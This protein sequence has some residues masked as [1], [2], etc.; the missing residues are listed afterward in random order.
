MHAHA[1]ACTQC[2]PVLHKQ[3]PCRYPEKVQDGANNRFL[4]ANRVAW[5]YF[6]HPQLCRTRLSTKHLMQFCTNAVSPNMVTGTR[7]A[8]AVCIVQE[9]SLTHL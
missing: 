2:Q 4:R 8:A 5:S 1:A 9:A 6:M 7:L 3:Q